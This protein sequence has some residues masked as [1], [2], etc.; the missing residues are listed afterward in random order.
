MIRRLRIAS[1]TIFFLL[2]LYLLVR[3]QYSGSDEIQLPVKIL[4]EIDPLHLLSTLLATGSV[5]GMMWL[6][7]ITVLLTLLFGRFF[8]GWVCPLGTLIQ[9]AEKLPIRRKKEILETNR[10]HR[11][12]T[13]KFYLLAGLLIAALFGMQWSGV[14]DPLSIAVRS[15]GLVVLPA[16]EMG[17][18]SLFEAAYTH[19]PLG[20][21]EITEPIYDA[22]QG[23]LIS[24]QQPHF[25]QPFLFGLIFSGILAL[26]FVRYRFWCR[27]LCPLGALLGVLAR[28]GLFRIHQLE[29]CTACHR[30]S[31]DC[32]G[33]AEPETLGGWKPSE[34]VVCGNCTAACPESGLRM[35]FALPRLSLPR[36]HGDVRRSAVSEGAAS[37]APPSA[38]A[39]TQI[40]R[41][42]LLLSGLAGL[43]SVPFMRL[44]ESELRS[45]PGLIRPPGALGEREFLQR[46]VRCGECMK[47]CLTGGLQPTLLEAGLEGLWSPRLVPRMGYC[48]YNCTLC[49]QVC[50][51]GAIR[52]LVPEEKKKIR[53]GLAIIDTTRC[54][55]YAFQSNCI[56]C[57]EHCPTPKKAIWFEE[58]EVVTQTG[59]RKRV[60]QPH[61]NIELCIGC[62]ICETKCPVRDLPAI[63]V[64]SAN[65][66]RN[67]GNRVLLQRPPGEV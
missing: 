35:G 56:V 59:E 17:L 30:C 3:T 13:I 28:L 39:G 65:E 19:N 34:C 66:D 41:R 37:V 8:C 33:A 32:Q 52:R 36:L 47:V 31:F 21:S 67:P 55:P 38:L 12:Q 48:E 24:F 7:F 23:G 2:F 16:L 14:L 60:K 58:V 64:T 51:T 25:H 6:A 26:S 27:I 45:D 44:G 5:H 29:T 63:R 20:I 40:R 4:L 42:H 11:A 43:A 49:G 1:Q 9:L 53:I 54:L 22:L 10:W 61:V 50:P 18:R 46:C 57:E 15:M 62:G